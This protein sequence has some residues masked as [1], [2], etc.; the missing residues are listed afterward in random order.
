M[1]QYYPKDY[2]VYQPYLQS[3][4][5]VQLQGT[6]AKSSAGGP[7]LQLQ[8]QVD[9]HHNP[10]LHPPELL[11]I[12]SLTEM[13]N[14]EFELAPQ[15]HECFGSHSDDLSE[16]D[17]DE[18]MFDELHL[19][20]SAELSIIQELNEHGRTVLPE[21]ASTSALLP[22]GP[23]SSSQPGARLGNAG[24]PEQQSGQQILEVRQY[25]AGKFG[26]YGASKV[27]MAHPAGS[28]VQV[29]CKVAPG[30]A[31]GET[32]GRHCSCHYFCIFLSGECVRLVRCFRSAFS[33]HCFCTSSVI[34]CAPAVQLLGDQCLLHA[35][36][37]PIL[38]VVCC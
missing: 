14:T 1:L 37:H 12:L 25:F 31:P 34:E 18:A 22:P 20:D 8:I 6:V 15:A 11:G 36:L 16:D 35:R 28:R 21:D 27:A 2:I 9:P 5:F 23:A 32:F 38:R 10:L 19:E 30:A 3:D 33:C 13:T 4:A 26:R 7:Y 17:D 29:H 24:N